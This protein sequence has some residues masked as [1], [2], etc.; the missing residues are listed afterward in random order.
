MPYFVLSS[1]RI[2]SEGLFLLLDDLGFVYL[3]FPGILIVYVIKFCLIWFLGII[4]FYEWP[5]QCFSVYICGTYNLHPF[6]LSAF[7]GPSYLP[8]STSNFGC[9]VLLCIIFPLCLIFQ[10]ESILLIYW[11]FS[12]VIVDLGFFLSFSRRNGKEYDCHTMTK[13]MIMYEKKYKL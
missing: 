2:V 11:E 6:L 10:Q 5:V 3:S 9:Q 4:S 8:L 1:N 12:F 7:S 13:T